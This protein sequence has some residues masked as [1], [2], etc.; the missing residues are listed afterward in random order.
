MTD[1]S[2]PRCGTKFAPPGWYCSRAE[3]GQN[4]PCALHPNHPE[5]ENP[6]SLGANVELRA[7][8]RK[9]LEKI[10]KD[11]AKIARI[12]EPIIE[13]TILTRPDFVGGL[14][15]L[16]AAGSDRAPRLLTRLINSLELIN[17]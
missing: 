10:D 4:S 3:H 13:A 7:N 16:C 8:L 12:E 17:L 1:Q 6:G 9:L 11:A 15:K 2:T 14:L 5:E